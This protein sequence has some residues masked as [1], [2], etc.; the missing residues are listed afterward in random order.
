MEKIAF[1]GTE[2][3]VSE[4]GL[5]TVKYGTDCP[6]EAAFEQMDVFLDAGGN[7]IDTAL[8]YGKQ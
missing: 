7:F 1:N 6:R 8:V 2:L 5:G 4:L 3:R